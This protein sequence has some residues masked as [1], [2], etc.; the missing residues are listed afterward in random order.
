LKLKNRVKFMQ[1]KKNRKYL[2]KAK[3]W[4]DTVNFVQKKEQ[5]KP[6]YRLKVMQ[7]KE[8]I[9]RETRPRYTDKDQGRQG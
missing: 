1:K 2:I 7:N 4:G 3:M 5:L 8:K 9:K 6:K